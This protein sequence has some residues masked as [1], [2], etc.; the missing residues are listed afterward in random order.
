[1]TQYWVVTATFA[2]GLAMFGLLRPAAGVHVKV[3]GSGGQT[4]TPVQATP[5]T[6]PVPEL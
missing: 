3:N 2:V 1:M 6:G 5:L 4:A